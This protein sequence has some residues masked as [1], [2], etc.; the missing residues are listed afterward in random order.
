MKL[1][2]SPITLHG[3]FEEQVE[4]RPEHPAIRYNGMSMTYVELNHRANLLAYELIRRGIQPQDHVAVIV[5]RRF[6][7]IIALLAVL[8]SGAA[9]VPI[10]PGYPLERKNYILDHSS[11][12][13]VITEDQERLDV[14]VQ[15]V[16]ETNLPTV[17]MNQPNPDIHVDEHSLAYIM[18]TSGST[19]LPKGV[20]IEQGPAVN[21]IRWVNRELSI[22]SADKVL[23]LTSV[24]FDLSVYDIF[25][26][27]A[28]GGTV[29]L[30]PEEQVSDPGQLRR[31]LIEE[32][33]TFWNSVPTTLLYLIRYL[34]E[35]DP[36]CRLP[37][38]R[39]LF[40]SGDWIPLE[41]A[42]SCRS[43]FP[44]ASLTALGGATEATVWSIYYTV[45][46]VSSEWNS[47]PY[48][49]P[50]DGNL[51]YILDEMGSPVAPGNTGEMFIGGIGLARGYLKEPHKTSKSFLPDPFQKQGR[52]YRT[53]D[54]GRLM[55]D[56]NI[57]FLGRI[58]DQVKIRGYRVEIKEVEKRLLECPGVKD[59]A[60]TARSHEHGGQYL[61]AYL[62]L[63]HPLELYT[64]KQRLSSQL[65]TYMLPSI[66]IRLDAL[67][68][69]ANGKVDKKQ[70]PAPSPVMLMIDSGSEPCATPLEF[71]LQ[72][73]WE[74][75]LPIQGIGAEQDFME[76]GGSSI[77]A[78]ALHSELLRYGFSISF[79][80]LAA[81]STIRTQASLLEKKTT[82]VASVR[83]ES[84]AASEEET[85]AV[86]PRPFN[87]FFYKSCLY[88]SLFPVL[89]MFG[90]EPNSL[91]CGEVFAYAWKGEPEECII[92]TVPMV[93]ESPE[94]ALH[95]LHL[96]ADFKHLP[97]GDDLLK[98][99][100][101]GLAR[102]RLFIV[103]LDSFYQP[104]RR[105]AFRKRHI[106][107]TLLVYGHDAASGRYLILEH[108]HEQALNYKERSITA[109]DLLNSCLG[110]KEHLQSLADGY[111]WIEFP[112]WQDAYEY[113]LAADRAR[114]AALFAEYGPAVIRGLDTLAEF[115]A[116]Y[117]ARS[118][119]DYVAFAQ[120]LLPGVTAIIDSKRA[121]IY[122][123]ARLFPGSRMIASAES[124]LESWL[125]IRGDLIRGAKGLP[126]SPE[127]QAIHLLLLEGI[128]SQERELAETLCGG[129]GHRINF[130]EEAYP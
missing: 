65:P 105:D 122:R 123:L 103:W 12:F 5:S 92:S 31:L 13:A 70:L 20:M 120:R 8:K 23:F 109:S 101:Y 67:P 81:H 125:E 119:T 86:K 18:Y 106:P 83:N 108:S 79:E 114:M 17:S 4:R 85:D 41:L 38:L 98:Q 43:R 62:T 45:D 21:L 49:K 16:L 61:C 47:I 1:L 75:V 72:K 22:G 14:P 76:I 28:A 60:V 30:C 40:V 116:L 11:A 6:E 99:L 29:V 74:K 35:F 3:L 51:F 115:K 126:L 117:A 42:R 37:M 27:L 69:N 128:R 95:R 71:I 55:E 127:Q 129:I 124:V 46:E 59:A 93:N 113:D 66:F 111:T 54:L 7:L 26:M 118:W 84:I 78:V 44:H 96:K 57:E 15:I 24:C 19:G 10:E 112:A 36:D 94:E 110:Y 97:N 121:E 9:Y 80:E 82:P 56:G 89:Q 63:S 68:L 39:H 73:L 130:E 90:R 58:D 50:I 53:G 77:E 34:A 64:L 100:D 91:L 2:H 48:G 52:M 33:V 25:G 107:H 102:R 104:D 87:S 32:G 88:N